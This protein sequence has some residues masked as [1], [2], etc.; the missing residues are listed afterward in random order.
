[1]ENVFDKSF[2]CKR[3]DKKMTDFITGKIKK[4]IVRLDKKRS[5]KFKFD[6]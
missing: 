4:S 3:P 1:M 5:R 6:N 2:N